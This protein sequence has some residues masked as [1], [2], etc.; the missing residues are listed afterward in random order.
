MDKR[1][2]IRRSNGEQV[3][4]RDL[5]EKIVAWINKFK[6]I[7]V[8]NSVDPT[9]ASLPWAC[10]RFILQASENELIP[11]LSSANVVRSVNDSETFT[12]MAEGMEHISRLIGAFR[13]R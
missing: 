11:G 2:K 6:E 13:R 12:A 7:G 9:Y 3:V 8:C 1:W 4:L 10:I 5:C